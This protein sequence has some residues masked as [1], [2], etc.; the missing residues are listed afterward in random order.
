MAKCPGQ[1]KRFWKPEDIFEIDCP[2][3]GASVEF[4]KDDPKLRCPQCRQ[5]LTNPK[6]DLSCAQWCKY[7]REC[8]GTLSASD[9]VLCSN[10][11]DDV[12]KLFEDDPK[13]IEHVTEVLK[14]A[15][16]IQLT[17]GGDPLVVKAAAILHN[18]PD[19]AKD[20]LTNHGVD[21][22]LIQLVCQT[23]ASLHS[24]KDMDTTEFEIVW[25]AVRLT[26]FTAEFPDANPQNA[27]PLIDKA[28]KTTQGRKLAKNLFTNHPQ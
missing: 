2:E 18:A 15:E 8:L 5:L 25:D 20:I 21:P 23:I 4:W 9:S 3:C 27:G 19:I 16:T 10:L 1:D 7:A 24:A 26:N 6:L 17:E 12:K 13:A 14:Y 28:F 11:I 22:E